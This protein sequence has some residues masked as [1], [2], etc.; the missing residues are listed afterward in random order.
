M[1]SIINNNTPAAMD[2]RL[3]RNFYRTDEACCML[4]SK[5][6]CGSKDA[7]FWADELF[8]SGCLPEVNQIL[9]EIWI[10]FKGLSDIQWL[11]LWYSSDHDY[12]DMMCNTVRLCWSIQD[13]IDIRVL[14]E[15]II[16]TSTPKRKEITAQTTH[17]RNKL[18]KIIGRLSTP[19]EYTPAIGAL[20]RLALKDPDMRSKVY[21]LVTAADLE[22]SPELL[23]IKREAI[24]G[25]SERGQMSEAESTVG[26]IRGDIVKTLINQGTSYWSEALVTYN[27]EEPDEFYM[28]HFPNDIP[29]E[30]SLEKQMNT[31]GPGSLFT[32]EVGASYIKLLRRLCRGCEEM[33]KI[34]SVLENKVI[35]TNTKTLFELTTS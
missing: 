31:H 35:P 18:F 5:L 8:S 29:D 32:T 25:L 19:T 9:F 27:E 14:K 23:P 34:Y 30:W 3:T 12:N 20:W 6:I 21:R 1:R 4:R 17:L 13:G 33:E 26:E 10:F 22:F 2:K 15:S 24:Y 11:L 16:K 7:L 28:K